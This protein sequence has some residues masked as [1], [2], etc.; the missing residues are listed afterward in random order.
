MMVAL[1]TNRAHNLNSQI[2]QA[3]AKVATDLLHV[4]PFVIR[5]ASHNRIDGR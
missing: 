3:P 5:I 4:N 2:P 1:T